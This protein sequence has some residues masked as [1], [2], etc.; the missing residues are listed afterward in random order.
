MKAPLF[1]RQGGFIYGG[2][3]MY[4]LTF[5]EPRAAMIIEDELIKMG[6]VS[7]IIHTPVELLDVDC[8][9]CKT[10]IRLKTLDFDPT[11]LSQLPLAN[12]YSYINQMYV[13]INST[14][15]LLEDVS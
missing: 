5:Y 15:E 2:T 13:Q 12:L 8:F 1:K 7:E 3:T 9:Y 14:S 10:A 6:T 4:I 11:E